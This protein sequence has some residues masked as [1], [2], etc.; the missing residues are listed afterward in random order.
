MLTVTLR[1]MVAHRLRL[2]LTTMSIAL[3]VAFLAGTFVLTDT[4]HKAFDELFGKVSK[5]TAAVVRGRDRG[6]TGAGA[7]PRAPCRRGAARADPHVDPDV[8]AAEGDVSGTP[9]SPTPRARRSSPRAAHRPSG[10]TMLDRRQ[11]CAATSTRVPAGHRAARTRSSSTSVL[12]SPHAVGAQINILFHGPTRAFTSSGSPPSAARRTSAA[13]RP[14]TS[15]W[16]P[17]SRC[18]GRPGVRPDQCGRGRRGQPDALDRAD[19]APAERRRGVTG[20]AIAEEFSDDVN[21]GLGFV[22]VMFTIF[23][24]IALFVGSFIIWNAFTMI[25]TQRTREIAAAAGGGASRGR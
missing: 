14:R 18:S 21:D 11:A 12:R 2:V 19:Q 20:K 3:G 5:G 10:L 15:I 17:R 22:T 9:S 8:R 13:R 16:R 6:Y 7:A 4:M 24:A 23:A 25:V 1:S